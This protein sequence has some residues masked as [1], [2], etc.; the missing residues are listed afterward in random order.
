MMVTQLRGR[1]RQLSL[2][3]TL[4]LLGTLASCETQSGAALQVSFAP[5][6]IDHLEFF[7]ANATSPSELHAIPQLAPTVK[8]TVFLRDYAANDSVTPTAGD[9]SFVY[10]VPSSATPKGNQVIVVGYLA[11]KPVSFDRETIVVSDSRVNEY[12]LAL[13]RPAADNVLADFGRDPYQC[14]AVN[15]GTTV[16]AVTRVDDID[17]DGAKTSAEPSCDI[18]VLDLKAS[19]VESCDGRDSGGDCV[20]LDYR[21]D[22]FCAQTDIDGSYC[23][24]GS[25]FACADSS[26]AAVRESAC[27]GVAP[28]SAEPANAGA[29]ICLEPALC[30][31]PG[32]PGL[33]VTDLVPTLECR[34]TFRPGETKSC[35]KFKLSAAF[36]AGRCAAADYIVSDSTSLKL[37]TNAVASGCFYQGEVLTHVTGQSTALV[38]I[39]LPVDA[40]PDVRRLTVVKLIYDE[41]GICGIEH[42][43]TPPFAGPGVALRDNCEGP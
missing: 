42:L 7:F 30:A 19:A 12:A 3:V 25:S 32:G 9:D 43:C 37:Q 39:T 10:F 14:I 21:V 23:R 1:L 11:G 33:V 20:R 40:R 28:R 17:C 36:T 13:A 22:K 34:V 35:T 8:P 6:S 31:R 16:D 18:D 38:G 4:G 5:G 26:P 15:T 27:D 29:A 2:I 24:L 41:S